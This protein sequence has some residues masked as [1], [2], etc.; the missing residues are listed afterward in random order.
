MARVPSGNLTSR[1]S[2]RRLEGIV[3]ALGSQG[4]RVL[5]RGSPWMNRSIRNDQYH[6]DQYGYEQE[7]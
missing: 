4:M 3:A 7:A 6:Y 2:L 1:P 5:P